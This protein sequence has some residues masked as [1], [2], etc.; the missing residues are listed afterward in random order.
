M[1]SI[2]VSRDEAGLVREDRRSARRETLR[3]RIVGGRLLRYAPMLCRRKGRLYDVMTRSI[4][5][6]CEYHCTIIS[7]TVSSPKFQASRI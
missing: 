3:D 1:S 2:G 4:E 6:Y 7:P 5:L